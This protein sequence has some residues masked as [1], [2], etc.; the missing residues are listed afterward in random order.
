MAVVDL[1]QYRDLMQ[2]TTGNQ[3]T[4]EEPSINIDDQ[5]LPESLALILQSVPENRRS[6]ALLIFKYLSHSGRF[7]YHADTHGNISIDTYLLVGTNFTD[8]IYALVT[9]GINKNVDNETHVNGLIPFMEL[10]ASTPCPS[11]AIKNINY[12]KQFLK[13]KDDASTAS[14]TRSAKW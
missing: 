2:R 3:E 8:I 13:I 5:A 7:L 9:P 10:L 4:V 14:T 12:R 1:Q 11:N 6:A